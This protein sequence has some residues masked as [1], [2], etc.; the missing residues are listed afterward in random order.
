MAIS[1]YQEYAGTM[2]LSGNSHWEMLGTSPK[3]QS[4]NVIAFDSKVRK[5]MQA[6]HRSL[7]QESFAS[8]QPNNGAPATGAVTSQAIKD[9]MVSHTEKKDYNP[10]PQMPFS[11]SFA[12]TNS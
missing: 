2:G 1:T 5:A 6:T 10:G 7:P 12:P 9:A 8:T 4:S 11:P 3:G